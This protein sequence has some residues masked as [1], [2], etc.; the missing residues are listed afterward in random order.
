MD[1]QKLKDLYNTHNAAR[2]ILDHAARRHRNQAETKVDR[3]LSIL[4]SEGHDISR[5][6]VIDAFKRLE[7]LGA[8]QF[9]AGRR[10]WPSRFVWSVGMVSVGKAAAG[11]A[12]EIEQLAEEQ[13]EDEPGGDL[14]AH[15][16][17]LRADLQVALE[18]PPDLTR[19]EADRLAAF[20]KTLPIDAE[21]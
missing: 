3:I 17:H 19:N 5:G 14:L 8:G 21:Q 11:E 6:Q 9:V 4:W 10:G 15:T 13:A 7:E 2:M 18:L 1:T 12:Q 20:I 16:F